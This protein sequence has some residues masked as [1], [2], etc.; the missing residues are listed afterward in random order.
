MSVRASEVR[1]FD[2]ASKRI[3]LAV[4]NHLFDADPRKCL[5]SINKSIFILRHQITSAWHQRDIYQIQ[6]SENVSNSKLVHLLAETDVSYN[7]YTRVCLII[8]LRWWVGYSATFHFCPSV[9]NGN[10]CF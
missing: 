3:V 7:L 10:R 1:S 5:C 2:S 4:T 6:T 9:T 8:C